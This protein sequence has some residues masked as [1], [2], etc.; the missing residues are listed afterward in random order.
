M[1]PCRGG[2]ADRALRRLRDAYGAGQ[3][4]TATLEVR[5]ALALAGR[6]EDAVWDLPRWRVSP[7]VRALVLGSYEWPLDERGRWTIGRS[8]KCEIPLLD[9]AVSRRHAEIAVRAGICL[10]RDLGSCNGTLLNGR[11]V[12][13]RARAGVTCWIGET[14]SASAD[15]HRDHA[16]G[17]RGV[18]TSSRP[19]PVSIAS[20]SAGSAWLTLTVVWSPVSVAVVPLPVSLRASPGRSVD[21]DAVGALS[22]LAVIGR[23]AR[24]T[25]TSGGRDGR[26][27]RPCRRRRRRRGR[28]PRAGRGGET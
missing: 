8:S 9:D 17:E 5:T 19:R 21:R 18:S 25:S 24:L 26:R 27:S 14:G 6:G 22:P 23:P 7:P 28:S 1:R 4:S 11:H 20:V 3:A 2:A 16:R 13:G 10:V 12:R 15:L